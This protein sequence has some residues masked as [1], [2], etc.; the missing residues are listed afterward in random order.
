MLSGEGEDAAPIGSAAAAGSRGIHAA[1]RHQ[2]GWGVWWGGAQRLEQQPGGWALAHLFFFLCWRNPTPTGSLESH[3][4]TSHRQMEATA[5]CPSEIFHGNGTACK[6]VALGGRIGAGGIFVVA[7]AAPF[8]GLR[9]V[10]PSCTGNHSAAGVVMSYVRHGASAPPKLAREG[11]E[12]ASGKQALSSWSFAGKGK[13]WHKKTLDNNLFFYLAT[14]VTRSNT[15]V[16]CE[17]CAA[18]LA[19]APRLLSGCRRLPLVDVAAVQSKPIQ[20]PARGR[21]ADGRPR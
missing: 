4:Q 7:G 3:V 20:H 13:D 6:S 2:V 14:K 21:C 16:R 9:S 8:C 18:P 1:G 19:P 5:V 17:M 10:V 15:G 12:P 11:A